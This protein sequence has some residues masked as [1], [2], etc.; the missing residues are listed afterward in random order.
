MIYN[1]HDEWDINVPLET[2]WVLASDPSKWQQWWPGLKNV[3]ITDQKS[4]V[5]GSR[6]SLMW[7]S[8][9]GYK[10]KHAVTITSIQ[11]RSNI[12]FNSEGDL[13]GSG[14]WKFINQGNQ[15]H[16]V[17]DWHVQTTKVWMNVLAPLLRPI[18]INN[19]SALMKRGEA[20]LNAHVEK[21][22]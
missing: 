22:L 4:N 3:I 19:H 2:A 1:F 17:I 7:R 8:K 18:F 13:K 21:G 15:T 10:L 11:P 6:A 14:I 9:T 5:V 16:M 20:G 12:K